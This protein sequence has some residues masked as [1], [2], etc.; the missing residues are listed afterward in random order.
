MLLFKKFLSAGTARLSS[1]NARAWSRE[2]RELDIFSREDAK[3]RREEK[4]NEEGFLAA[5]ERR[6]RKEKTQ[7]FHA[8]EM[9]NRT[10]IGL[11]NDSTVHDYALI[12]PR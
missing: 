8:K 1:P 10:M 4:E 5:K 6:E 7:D 11:K 2:R 3:P 9:R 12:L